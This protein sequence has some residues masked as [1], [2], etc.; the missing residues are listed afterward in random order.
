MSAPPPRPPLPQE[1]VNGPP[2]PRPPM[3][4]TDDEEGLFSSEPGSNRPIHMA[5][6]G[7]YQEVK[8]VYK[9]NMTAH[10]LYTA[11]LNR[12]TQGCTAHDLY[13]EVKQLYTCC[14]WS[15]PES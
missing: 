9:T 6:H 7:L 11:K 14:T 8:Q 13:Q 2:P 3:P 5:A 12:Y 4:D 10:G 15:L 1:V